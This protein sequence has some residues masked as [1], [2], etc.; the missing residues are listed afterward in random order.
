MTALTVILW[1]VFVIAAYVFLTS[2]HDLV[3]GLG[4]RQ[5]RRQAAFQGLDELIKKERKTRK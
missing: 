1:A 2:S 3:Q 5:R 4:D